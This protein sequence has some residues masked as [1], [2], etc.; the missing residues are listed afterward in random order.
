[1]T[2]YQE[3]A[4]R[5]R[6]QGKAALVT[7]A[8]SGIGAAV[9]AMFAREGARVLCADI[10]GSVE[11]TAEAITAAGGVASA[12]RADVSDEQQV[13]GMVDT[14]AARLGTLDIL[15]AN[16]GINPEAD[17]GAEIARE[18]WDRVLAVNLSGVFLSCKYAARVMRPR[19]AGSIVAMASV[20]GLI[21]WG[22]SAAYLASKG[23]VISFTRGLAAEYAR[24]NVRVNCVCPATV[25]TPMVSVQFE[26]LPDREERLQR[27]AAL[28]PLGRVGTPEDVA[29]GVLYLASDEAAWVTGTAL[30][31]DGG[32]TAV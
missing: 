22:G 19:R 2:T 21:G 15:V 5:G 4:A 31:I 18:T 29:Y 17:G 1:M 10:A 28:H 14:A 27:N 8:G 20:S 7:G 24:D 6:L 13:A 9:A 26:Q 30:V 25:W 32:M 16:A 23:A 12:V 11:A 3:R